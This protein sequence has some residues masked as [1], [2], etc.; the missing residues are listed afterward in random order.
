MAHSKV[1]ALVA[2][3]LVMFGCG[4][5]KHNPSISPEPGTN[6][7][8]FVTSYWS[9]AD[10]RMQPTLTLLFSGTMEATLDDIAANGIDKVTPSY[11]ATYHYDSLNRHVR[12]ESVYP[13]VKLSDAPEHYR[14]QGI[15]EY[16]Y[17]NTS[18]E[19]I[20]VST[21]KSLN[22]ETGRLL[23]DY[24]IGFDVNFSAIRLGSDHSNSYGNS[25]DPQVII[26]SR[27][28]DIEEK[29]NAQG[30]LS[31]RI[32]KNS[33][34]ETDINDEYWGRA[35]NGKLLTV[36][37]QYPSYSTY[38]DFTYDQQ[39]VL[40]ER[41]VSNDNNFDGVQRARLWVDRYHFMMVEGKYAVV[42]ESE[43]DPD[44]NASYRTLITFV[45]DK[46]CHPSSIKRLRYS[47]PEDVANSCY[48]ANNWR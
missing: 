39:G 20:D 28:Y 19:I 10:Y 27:D 4:G 41:T 26:N 43:Y 38:L 46:P 21:T 22:M 2:M 17:E 36:L 44:G 33:I 32:R 40:L 1:L 42:V 12:S 15:K 8:G 31:Y 34:D 23:S 14:T 5:K 24:W 6:Q 7:D 11:K 35:D 9:E 18:G 13:V 29:F 3:S 25:D 16:V 37:R 45:E 48:D 30:L 47:L